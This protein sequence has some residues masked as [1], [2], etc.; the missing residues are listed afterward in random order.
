ME[1]GITNILIISTPKDLP[2]FIDLLGDGSSYGLTI[3]YEVQNK[4]NGIAEAFIIG[5]KFISNNNVC[6]ILGDNIFHSTKI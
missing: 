1:I 4:P 5:S 2:K 6:L 3:E